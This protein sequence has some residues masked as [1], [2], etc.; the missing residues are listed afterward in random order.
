MIWGNLNDNR[1]KATPKEKA[2]CPLCNF[3]SNL[4]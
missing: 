1:V 4:K 3:I 2:K